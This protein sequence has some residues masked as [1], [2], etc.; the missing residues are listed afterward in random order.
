M[1]QRVGVCVCV[2]IRRAYNTCAQL[3]LKTHFVLC[4]L[5]IRCV[6][7][8]NRDVMK[9]STRRIYETAARILKTTGKKNFSVLRVLRQETESAWTETRVCS[10]ITIEKK[11]R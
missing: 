7:Y 3:R 8:R 11:A 1:C 9:I 2:C 5:N 10:F 4:S 6:L